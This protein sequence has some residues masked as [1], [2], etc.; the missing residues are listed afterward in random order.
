M[1]YKILYDAFFKEV[2]NPESAPERLQSDF[3]Q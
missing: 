3:P 1:L 2:M